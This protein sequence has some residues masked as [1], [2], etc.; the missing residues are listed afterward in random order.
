MP[1][2]LYFYCIVLTLLENCYLVRFEADNEFRVL[3]E[4]EVQ[5]LDEL[6]E[7]VMIQ[8]DIILALWGPDGQFYEAEV[9]LISN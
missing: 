2:F 9:L 5:P 3:N 4:S 8:G 6:D 1:S 7:E